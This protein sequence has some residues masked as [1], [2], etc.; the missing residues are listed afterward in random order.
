M[1]GVLLGVTL[2]VLVAAL[3]S[4]QTPAVDGTAAIRFAADR[5]LACRLGDSGAILF[6]PASEHPAKLVP[7]FSHFG[8]HGLLRAYAATGHQEYLAA[9]DAWIDWYGDH[10]GLD[11]TVTDYGLTP[12][13]ALTSTGEMD[14]TDAYAAMFLWLVAER[15]RAAQE[16]PDWLRK[17]ERSCV[18]ALSAVLLTLQ[19]DGLTTGKPDWPIEYL[20]DNADVVAGLRSADLIFVAL[21]NPGMSSHCRALAARCEK[22]LRG[23]FDPQRGYYAWHRDVNGNMAW[24]LGKWYPDVMAQVL[25]LSRI[26]RPDDPDRKVFDLVAERFL[27]AQFDPAKPQEHV[28]YAL[29]AQRV[30]ADAWADR[31]V[32]HLGGLTAE[33]MDKLDCLQCGLIIEALTGGSRP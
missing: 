17:R 16:P 27:S 32:T 31:L 33:T 30:A 29:A 24:E 19:D 21:G 14:S 13:H 5:I 25:F 3:P 18:L 7:Y 23:F 6:V 10:Q 1:T 8:A 15:W 11:G 2:R 9:A 26:G 28:W 22:G 20:M 4:T 12:E